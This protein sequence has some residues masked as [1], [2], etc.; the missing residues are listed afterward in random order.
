MSDQKDQTFQE[1]SGYDPGE[2]NNFAVDDFET[3]GTSGGAYD[4]QGTIPEQDEEITT[5]NAFGGEEPAEEDRYAAGASDGVQPSNPLI[6]WGDEEDESLSQPSA[7]VPDSQA[8]ALDD[9]G[10]LSAL[11]GAQSAFKSPSP[12]D[13]YS[14]PPQESEAVYST[15]PVSAPQETKAAGKRNSLLPC[16]NKRAF[17]CKLFSFALQE[18]QIFYFFVECKFILICSF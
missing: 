1:L 11:T 10:G 14:N 15:E 3:L 18:S 7:A 13:P 9:L 2:S 4:P 6:S 12:S 5:T 17:C 16:I 8:S